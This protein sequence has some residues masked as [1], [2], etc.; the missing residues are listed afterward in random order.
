[1]PEKSSTKI[2]GMK[3]LSNPTE[4]DQ[5]FCEWRNRRYNTG[6]VPNKNC[7]ICKYEPNSEAYQFCEQHNENP[8]RYNTRTQQLLHPGLIR[9]H[10]QDGPYDTPVNEE[11][12]FQSGIRHNSFF[13]R[14]K[15]RDMNP[16]TVQK[17]LRDGGETYSKKN[18]T[19]A[20]KR[21]SK[22]YNKSKKRS[23]KKSSTRKSKSRKNRKNRKSRK[24]I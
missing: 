12:E 9:G 14:G 11:G 4:K 23:S 17:V 10:L 1:M 22:N 8:E 7:D 19:A 18:Y 16:N 13:S 24:R 20:G 6:L 21:H 3:F 15:Y 5:T 2:G